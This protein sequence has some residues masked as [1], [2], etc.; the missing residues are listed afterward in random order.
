MKSSFFP[1]WPHM[2]PSEQRRLANFC[3]RSPGIFSIS[4]P[5][6]CT[7]SSCEKGSTKCSLKAYISEKVIRLKWYLR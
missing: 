7:T 3:Q 6:R 2:N 4:E 1:G 5:F